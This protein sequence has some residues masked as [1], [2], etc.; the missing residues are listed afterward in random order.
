MRALNS[1]MLAK[2]AVRE[3]HF[4]DSDGSSLRTIDRSASLPETVGELDIGNPITPGDPNDG[5]DPDDRGNVD[6]FYAISPGRWGELVCGAEE[7]SVSAEE[8]RAVFWHIRQRLVVGEQ[9]AQTPS[10]RPQ[11]NTL[12]RLTA[13][14]GRDSEKV[15]FITA[16]GQL[17]EAI[18][19]HFGPSGW[20]ALVQCWHEAAGIHEPTSISTRTPVASGSHPEEQPLEEHLPVTGRTSSPSPASLQSEA[21]VLRSLPGAVRR[22]W[23]YE[24]PL[25]PWRYSETAG[26]REQ[27][28]S[29]EQTGS[30][31]G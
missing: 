21:E 8:A 1:E 27:R 31:C 18:E 3:R 13:S 12:A 22:F 11:D 17:H 10:P 15:D 7:G 25:R 16:V 23:L 19:A 6:S 30:W 24:P 28:E 20:T 2:L 4:Q 5:V 9:A 14:E 29:M 26:D